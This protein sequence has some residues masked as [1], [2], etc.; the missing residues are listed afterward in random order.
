MASREFLRQRDDRS[1]VNF[2]ARTFSYEA[3]DVGFV[4]AFFGHVENT[5]DTTLR[6]L[7]IFS[8]NHFEDISL[9]QVPRPRL[10]SSTREYT[11]RPAD[12]VLLALFR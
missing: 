12:F 10:T 3:E 5:G 4:P 7:E 2:H 8:T 6:F 11:E 1:E 9:S